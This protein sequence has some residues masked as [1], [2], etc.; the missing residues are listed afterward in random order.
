MTLEELAAR[1]ELFVHDAQRLDGSARDKVLETI[2]SCVSRNI[3]LI[4][5]ALREK[6][7]RPLPAEDAVPE[8]GDGLVYSVLLSE[9]DI[10]LMKTGFS[11]VQPETTLAGE[12]RELVSRVD[13]A[14]APSPS[15]DQ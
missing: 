13:A 7:G 11:Y 5:A 2:G 9:R 6:E 4:S 8:H 12:L 15:A 10:S 14:K 3:G 1:L